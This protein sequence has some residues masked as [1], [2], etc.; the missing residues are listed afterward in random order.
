MFRT[1]ISPLACSQGGTAVAISTNT[2]AEI[3]Y[4]I[5]Y[6]TKPISC[7]VTP[8]SEHTFFASVLGVGSAGKSSFYCKCIP[9]SNPGD[10]QVWIC[11]LSVG[12]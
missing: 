2:N 9:V 3:T 12:C 1:G 7:V 10:A 8:F 5:S 6:N 11:Y 4:A